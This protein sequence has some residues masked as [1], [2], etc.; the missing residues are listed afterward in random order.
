MGR[1]RNIYNTQSESR[2]V[3]LAL[4]TSALGGYSLFGGGGPGFADGN[5]YGHKF[6][7]GNQ[8]PGASVYCNEGNIGDSGH[9][10]SNS[11]YSN[12]HANPHYGAS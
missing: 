5:G 3:A 11:R 12:H 6:G 1:G 7:A 2:R 10:H 4:S 8:E 9:H